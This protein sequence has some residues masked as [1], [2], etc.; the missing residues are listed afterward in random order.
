MKL[1]LVLVALT[2]SSF[3][4]AQDNPD[5]DFEG[6]LHSIFQK[7][8]S[9]P[10]SEADWNKLK[11]DKASES[12]QIQAGDSLWDV[13][14]T[15]FGTG[16]FWPKLWQLNDQITN[17]HLIYPGKTLNFVPGSLSSPPRLNIAE[18][19]KEPEV[20]VTPKDDIDAPVIPPP[21]EQNTKPVLTQLP[22]SLPALFG[23]P[24]G[25]G[26]NRNGVAFEEM[27]VAAKDSMYLT[28]YLTEEIPEPAGEVFDVELEGRKDMWAR[29]TFEKQTLFVQVANGQVNEFYTTYFVGDSVKGFDSSSSVGKPIMFTGEVRLI[30]KVN[31]EKSIFR[32]VLTK[33]VGEVSV[34]ALL[35]KGR[36]KTFSA[37]KEYKYGSGEAYVVGGVYDERRKNMAT[38]AFVFLDGGANKGIT[39][40][41]ILNVFKMREIRSGIKVPSLNPI[42]Q[43]LVVKATANRTTAYALKSTEIIEPGDFSGTSKAAL[44]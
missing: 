31:N 10:M 12:Y 26:Y 9:E 2:V 5:L 19:K 36:L 24:G 43:L 17:P 4:L 14:Q 13:S 20:Q 33:S 39:E 37:P 3:G 8:N 7:Y 29:F 1:K 38:G 6:R 22:K 27:K 44:E 25:D 32:A 16:Y 40:G 15:L 41:Q 23:S 28:T 42:A 21:E 34:G 11:S 35:M 30:Q 18:N